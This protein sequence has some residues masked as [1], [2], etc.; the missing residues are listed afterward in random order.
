MA[1]TDILAGVEPVLERTQMFRPLR[2]AYLRSFK[3]DY[4]NDFVIGPQLFYRQFVNSGSTVFDIGANVGTYT[5]A[6]LSLG[7]GKVVA[8]E[9]TPDL[10]RKL[11]YIRDKR[12]KVVGSAVG[13]EAGILPFNLSNF[14][15]LNSFSGEWI[16][17]VAQEVPAGRPQWISTVNVDV[18]T[19]DALIKEHG[20]PDFVK[21]DVEGAELQVLQGLTSSPKYLSFEFHSE[22]HD[23][24]IACIRQLCFSSEARFN[25]I[26]G[27]PSGKNSLMLS[28]WVG[29]EA[30]VG[31][32]RAG[33]TAPRVYG[34]I[35][36]RQ[37]PSRGL[38]PDC[39][40]SSE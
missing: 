35:F 40:S 2:N 5:E 10:V 29:A 9:P 20:I 27:E 3:R 36:V 28:E 33:L 19:L 4:W 8:V 26:L 25:Y 38:T 14:S 39:K 15:T 32:A 18:T 30:M 21:I 24:L 34:D 16:D 23:I 12:L 11:K 31:I 17:K 22:L 37:P 6:F 1:L 13:K 7:A